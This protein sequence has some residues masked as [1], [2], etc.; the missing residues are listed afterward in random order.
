MNPSLAQQQALA[1]LVERGT[2]TTDQ[3][4]AVRTALFPPTSGRTA[5]NPMSVLIEIVGYVGGALIFSGAMLLIGLNLD[6]LGEQRAAAVLAGYAVALLIAGLLIGGGPVGVL[7]LRD[8]SLP[9]RRR[10]V[11]VLWA[12]AAVPAAA[13]MALADRGADNVTLESGLVALAV[14]LLGYAVLPTVPG[15]LAVTTAAIVSTIGALMELEPLPRLA[16]MFTFVALGVLISA[17]AAARLLPPRR[18]AFALGAGIAIVG[19]H[20]GSF[21]ES[22]AWTYGLT[23]LIGLICFGGYWL[24]RATVLLV[25]GVIATSIAIPEAVTDWTDDA[26]SGP[27]ILL[28]SGAVLVAVSGLGL[29][30]RNLRQGAAVD[31]PTPRS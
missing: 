27:A 5:P 29:W 16:P 19:A 18:I 1:G 30:L 23:L 22:R 31:G 2:L 7:R 4:D 12:F 15:L 14:A 8:R 13:A 3:A 17:L 24:E 26:L 21:A 11:G 28:I 25:F 6:R 10:L 20:L 9:V